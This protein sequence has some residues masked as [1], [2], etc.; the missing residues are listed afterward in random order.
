QDT[1]AGLF[2]TPNRE[3]HPNQGRW[4]SPGPAGLAAANPSHPQSWNRYAYV[5]NRPLGAVDATGLFQGGPCG[6]FQDCNPCASLGTFG[7]CPCPPDSIECCDP[8]DPFCDG[9]GGGGGGGSPPSQLQRAG[10][11]FP[12]NETLG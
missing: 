8:S 6:S 1:I 12:N 5:G 4:I 9:R 10:G 7:P 3:L 2:D 11:R